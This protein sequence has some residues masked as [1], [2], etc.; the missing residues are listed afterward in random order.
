MATNSGSGQGEDVPARSTRD[1]PE[2]ASDNEPQHESQYP[3]LQNRIEQ[4]GIRNVNDLIARFCM[5]LAESG[6]STSN[7][8]SNHLS[9]SPLS[10]QDIFE[11]YQILEVVLDVLSNHLFNSVP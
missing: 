10:T 4:A 8:D 2:A 11:L 6:E 3:S 7:V 1:N 9:A 5:T